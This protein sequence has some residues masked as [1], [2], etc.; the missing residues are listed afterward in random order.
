MPKPR[1]PLL[2]MQPDVPWMLHAALVVA[3]PRQELSAV[4]R[5]AGLE[6]TTLLRPGDVVR[7]EPILEHQWRLETGADPR[8]GLLEEHVDA[9]AS[10]VGDHLD[11]L[12]QAIRDVDAAH[13]HFEAVLRF[14]DVHPPL[15]LSG[16]SVAILARLGAG[17]RVS[18]LV[19]A[20]FSFLDEAD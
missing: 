10:L 4:T 9:L 20:D 1:Q 13:V 3:D 19:E 14:V 18:V 11:T 6:P 5:L 7:D 16:D 8:G 17:L 12:A 2:V 15:R